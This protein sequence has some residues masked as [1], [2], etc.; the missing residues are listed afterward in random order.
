MPHFNL[1]YFLNCLGKL[2]DKDVFA[3][4]V[5][6]M[7]GKTF[8]PVYSYITNFGWSGLIL[9]PIQEHYASLCENYKD[10]TLIQCANIAIAEYTGKTTMHRI[11]TEYITNG[12][13]PKWGMGTASL[14]N[15]RNALEFDKVRPFIVE[16]EVDCM[17][18]PELLDAYKVKKIDLLQIDTE[19]FDYHVLKQLDFG[20]YHPMVINMEIV[21]LPKTEQSACK[22]LLDEQGY[23]HGK[24]GYDLMAISPQ[25]YRL[26]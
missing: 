2:R 20:S 5:G 18:L 25:L 8:D 15:N 11:P 23:L 21:N 1:H 9:E 3:L 16:E 10:N 7:D 14:Y 4:Q 17:T 26:C 19:G 6:A 13:V 24:M 22:R 12:D